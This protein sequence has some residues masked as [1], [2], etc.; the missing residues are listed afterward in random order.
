MPPP[1]RVRRKDAHFSM[2]RVVKLT[3]RKGLI[4]LVG[5]PLRRRASGMPRCRHPTPWCA[6]PESAKVASRGPRESNIGQNGPGPC[7][8]PFCTPRRSNRSPCAMLSAGLTDMTGRPH[9][10]FWT[11][12]SA[13]TPPRRIFW[14]ELWAPTLGNNRASG[15]PPRASSLPIVRRAPWPRPS[16]HRS[17][18][19]SSAEGPI[20]C[21]SV[22]PVVG[23][24]SLSRSWL[25]SS[26]T[27]A[28]P[29]MTAIAPE[30]A[31]H[32]RCSPSM[33]WPTSPLFPTWRPW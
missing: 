20:P 1:R 4:P 2:T 5:L 28:R 30:N 16:S 11:P 31:P 23:R 3:A 10:T 17:I 32:R 21:T 14:P 6:P 26:A 19:R 22:R 18:P 27:C 9:W 15:P 25:G 24:S 8:R 13:M 7:S 29:P 33:R 12:I